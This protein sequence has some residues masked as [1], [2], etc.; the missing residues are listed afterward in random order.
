MPT[1][2]A[3]IDG[4]TASRE[5]DR[6]TLARLAFWDAELGS[7]ELNAITPEHVD[8]ALVRLAERGRLRPLRNRPTTPSGKPLAGSTMNRYISQLQTVFKYARRLRLLPR[9]H[10]PPTKGIEKS[11][12]T[13]DPKRYLRPEE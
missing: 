7:L 2:R 3:T 5:L 10:V 4:F 11:P 9:A 13:A 6:A 8:S 1:L 12:E